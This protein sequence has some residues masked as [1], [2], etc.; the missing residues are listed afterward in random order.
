MYRRKLN[1]VCIFEDPAMFGGIELNPENEWIKLSKLIP[2]WVFEKKYAEQFAPKMGQPACSVRMAIGSLIIKEKY[3]LSDEATVEQIAMNPYFQ[4]FIGLTEYHQT[5]PFN[6]TMMTRFRQRLTTKMLEDVNDVIIGRK[7]VEDLLAEDAK[8]DD[9]HN[10]DEPPTQSTEAPNEGTLI[11]DATCAPQTIRFPTDPSLLNEA[12]LNTEDI[13]DTFHNA[14]L[15][16]GK[17]PRTY[18][19]M[20][21]NQYNSFSKTRK[22]SKKQINRVKKQQLQYLRRNLGYI[23]EI[24][25]RHPQ[26]WEEALTKWQRERLTVVRTLYSQQL[27]MYESHTNRVDDRI[28]SLS[29]WWVRPIV[30]GKQSAPVEF[31][32][33]VEMSDVGGFLRIETLKW[34]AF[35]ESTTL[36]DSVEAY[37]KSYG[38]YPQRVL[39]D[40]IF[41]TR[42]N[43]RYCKEHGIHLN[44]PKLGKPSQDPQVR[45]EELRLEW[46]ESGERGDIERCFG[47]CK[48]CYSLG[49]VTAK[50]KHTSEIMIHLSVLTLNLR[51]RLRLLFCLFY[52]FFTLFG[53]LRMA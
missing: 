36:Q 45:K 51:K 31:G 10:D 8:E 39:A 23:D 49:R 41:R 24:I 47:V 37:R 6:A 17:K 53:R 19:E 16:D 44:G 43:I 30:R 5:A 26:E 35:N 32:A 33:K 46:E 18:R 11:L 3:R 9:D 2:W 7:T 50:L 1:Q 13:I 20:A 4:F 28:V 29:Q 22:K 25:K 34:D 38:H 14:G 42:C 52:D 21:K 40:T 12:R 48:R 27:E 15:T